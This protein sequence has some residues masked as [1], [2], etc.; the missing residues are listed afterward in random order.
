MNIQKRQKKSITFLTMTWVIRSKT[1]YIKKLWGLK[2][3][4]KNNT[5]KSKIKKNTIKI[6]NVKIAIKNKSKDN[7][8][9]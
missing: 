4:K 5:K 7:K 3:Q 9:F 2:S 6:I 8:N 1:I